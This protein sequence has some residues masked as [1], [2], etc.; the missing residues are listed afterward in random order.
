[1]LTAYFDLLTAPVLAFGIPAMIICGRDARKEE[2]AGNK[3][4][5]VWLRIWFGYPA[6]WL[7]GYIISWGTKIL[8][9]V[10]SGGTWTEI[11]NQILLRSGS[12]FEGRKITVLDALQENF[13]DITSNSSLVLILVLC[14]FGYFLIRRLTEWKKGNLQFSLRIMLG[15]LLLAFMPIAVIMLM[16]NHT[17]QHAYMTFRGLSLTFASL[18]MLLTSFQ[19]AA[20][21]KKIN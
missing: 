6:A 3:S 5:T 16:V 11:I 7:A 21:E 10:L 19:P 8:L 4:W 2:K 17:Y 1:M 14:W 13:R 9:G 20:E 12:T 18:L 15:Y